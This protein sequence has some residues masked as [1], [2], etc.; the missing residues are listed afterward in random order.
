MAEKLKRDNPYPICAR[1]IANFGRVYRN[2][3]RVP[4]IEVTVKI[5]EDE[6]TIS[7]RFL[8][9][10]PFWLSHDDPVLKKM[11]EQ[12]KAKFKTELKD[13]DITVKIKMTV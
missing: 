6:A 4:M 11:I 13:P 2:A 3:N 9:Y 8:Q 12:V 1:Y 10:D 5:Q 7:E